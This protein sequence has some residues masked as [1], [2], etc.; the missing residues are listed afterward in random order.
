MVTWWSTPI[1]M[2]E[3]VYFNVTAIRAADGTPATGANVYLE[4]FIGNHLPPTLQP[5]VTENAP[6]VYTIGPM[7]FD[8]SGKWTVRFHFYEDCLDLLPDSPHGHSAYYI[9]VP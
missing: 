9:N 4:A 8:A 3:D 2:G 6:G 5:P 7:E 1:D